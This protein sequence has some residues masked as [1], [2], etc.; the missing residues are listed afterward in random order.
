M[1]TFKGVTHCRMVE[2]NH[3]C[4]CYLPRNLSYDGTYHS[5]YYY[6]IQR[7]SKLVTKKNPRGC[8][9]GSSRPSLQ[10]GMDSERDTCKVCT[11]HLPNR[12]IKS[13]D[14]NSSSS[15][16]DSVFSE[17]YTDM[18]DIDFKHQASSQIEADQD[19]DSTYLSDRSSIS[20]LE[21]EEIG[22]V[23]NGDAA[24]DSTSC[25]SSGI[26]IP[27]TARLKKP[28]IKLTLGTPPSQR[29]MDDSKM[30]DA[31][32]CGHSGSDDD[33][34]EFAFLGTEP[35]RR[36]TSLKTYKTPPGTPGRKKAV[37]FADALGLDL[38]KVRHILNLEDPPTV[39]TSALRDLKLSSSLDDD[40]SRFHAG[41]FR[42]AG[43]SK[44]LCTCFQQPCADP[45]FTDRVR[46]NKVS[47]ENCLVDDRDMTISGVV[48]V[49]NV[50]YQKSVVI[51]YSVNSWLTFEDVQTSY[52]LNSNDGFSDRFSFTINV[53]HYFSAGSKISFCIMY[54][55]GTDTYWDNNHGT[56]YVIECY[57]RSSSIDGTDSSWVHFIWESRVLKISTFLVSNISCSPETFVQTLEQ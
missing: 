23:D 40:R 11:G 3:N 50:S 28:Q 57:A 20:T 53:P 4:S 10:T 24:D 17:D 35:V 1:R 8:L 22:S 56:N 34:Q 41:P 9:A 49:A 36:A 31:R 26:D 29:K 19:A 43:G 46:A 55:T 30:E 7:I 37:R 18:N 48:R 45:G 42:S 33:E 15:L 44:Y 14:N 51:R 52:V 5:K 16:S 2:P 13:C 12:D 32:G 25:D 39:P 21:N 54:S 27:P 38:E 47:L 6:P